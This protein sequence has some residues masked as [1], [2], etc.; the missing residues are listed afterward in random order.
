MASEFRRAARSL[1]EPHAKSIESDYPIEEAVALLNAAIADG[2]LAGH[3]SLERVELRA[4]G[5]GAE[6]F[7]A[8]WKSDAEGAR[9][10]GEFPTPSGTQRWLR[11]VAM[12][13]TALIATTAWAV[14][15][16]SSIAMRAPIGFFTL[17][18]ILAFPYGIVAM[19]SQRDAREAALT[20]TLRK[21]LQRKAA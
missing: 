19:S 6:A 7:I 18:A 8:Q 9:L 2:T 4:P 3:V 1:V 20:K 5:R 15:T 11:A 10:E 13:L 16:D 12:G 21:A 14:F 17:F